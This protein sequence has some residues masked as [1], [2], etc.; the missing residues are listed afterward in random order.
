METMAEAMTLVPRSRG[1]KAAMHKQFK[2]SISR[3]RRWATVSVE[4]K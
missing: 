3:T 1:H 4:Q 2:R